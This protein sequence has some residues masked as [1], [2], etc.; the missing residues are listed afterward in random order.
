MRFTPHFLDEIRARLPLSEVV[1]RRVTWDRRKSQP[2]KGDYWACCPFHGE[3]TPS[4]HV[5]DRRGHYHCFGCGASGDHFR[6]LVETEGMAFPEAVE[7]LAGK[8]GVPMPA[9]DPESER[10]ERKRAGLG[11]V[12]EMACRFFEETLASPQGAAA[13]DYARGRRLTA[14]TLK[15]FRFGFAP[16]SRDALKRHLLQQGV[17]EA[18][19]VEAGLV[20]RPDDGRPS[21][22]RFRNRLIVPIQDMRGRVVAF[23]G[24]TIDPK[25][26]PKY[27]NSPETT[28]FHKGLMLFNAHRARKAALESGSVIVVEGYLDAIAVHQA[29]VEAVVATLGTAFTEDQMNALWRLATEPVVCFDGD[30]A[31]TAAAHRAVD[32]ILPLLK[33]GH[34]FN[35]TFLPQGQDP[36][37]MIKA[38]GR[39]A[40]LAEVRSA[41]PLS[42][43]LWERETAAA[44]IDTPERKAALEKRL[45]DLV[46][47]IRDGLVSRRYAQAFRVRLSELFWQQTRGGQ[48]ARGGR[49]SRGGKRGGSADV[50]AGVTEVPAFAFEAS[51]TFERMV[52]G[53]CVEYPELFERH[54]ERLH[55]IP[56][57]SRSCDQFK[58]QLHWV[59]VGS[60]GRDVASLY[61]DLDSSFFDMLRGVH[62]MGALGNGPDAKL[63]AGMMAMQP[64]LRFRPPEA[65]VEAY[66][67]LLLD[68][69]E[70]RAMRRELDEEVRAAEDEIDEMTERR[71]LE[72][73]RDINRREEEILRREQELAEE[74]RA[75][76]ASFGAGEGSEMGVSAAG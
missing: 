12:V 66:L 22:D 45:D 32:R 34:S 1:A 26:E 4:F 53:L 62:G 71:I 29:G 72:M 33:S 37:D 17:D 75:I 31:G 61:G 18:S 44:Q 5:D 41:K 39:E 55:G 13:R 51:T 43:V 42:D 6:F 57:E 23:G 38:G 20:I 52:L 28:L 73:S 10:R 60:H 76:R 35:F 48:Q 46:G 19:L 36:D 50:P 70:V 27:L 14:E 58:E 9:R 3:K 67:E 59:M 65:F 15:E 25:R 47:T 2:A 30:A 74:A 11:D 68:R 40:F 56:F 63:R 7:E 24:R 16:D 54:Y 21:Y 49:G 8:A 69:L 64:I